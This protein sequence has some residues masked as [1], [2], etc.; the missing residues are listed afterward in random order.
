MLLVL[1]PQITR[2]GKYAFQRTRKQR[3]GEFKGFLEVGDGGVDAG[4]ER[5]ELGDDAFLFVER[6]KRYGTKLSRIQYPFQVVY[7]CT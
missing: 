5:V 6:W 3:L 4:E 7:S 1:L 2:W